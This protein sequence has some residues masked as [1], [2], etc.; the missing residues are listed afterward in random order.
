MNI[1]STNVHLVL[2]GES[3]RHRARDCV[4]EA[5]YYRHFNSSIYLSGRLSVCLIF[6]GE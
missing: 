3:K 1:E 5:M 2:N 4:V 6:F